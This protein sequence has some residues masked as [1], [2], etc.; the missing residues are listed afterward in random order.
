MVIMDFSMFET[1]ANQLHHRVCRL[2]VL[3][4]AS[5][6]G[7]VFEFLAKFLPFATATHKHRFHVLPSKLGVDA[8]V[9][10]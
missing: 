7:S 10:R 4:F 1:I 2:L 3:H 5:A 9:C 8:V 6:P